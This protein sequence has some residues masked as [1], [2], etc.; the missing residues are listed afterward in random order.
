MVTWLT[1]GGAGGSCLLLTARGTE[2]EIEPLVDAQ[3]MEQAARA[4]GFVRS[5]TLQLPDR[6]TIV[7]WRRPATC[8]VTEAAGA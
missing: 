6:R 1:T 8:P 5:S 7:I 2:F 4:T 3:L